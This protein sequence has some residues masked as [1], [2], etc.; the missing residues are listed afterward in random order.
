MIRPIEGNLF[1]TMMFLKQCFKKFLYKKCRSKRGCFGCLNKENQVNTAKQTPIGK[2]KTLGLETT[3]HRALTMS[4]TSYCIEKTDFL[5]S[6]G[7]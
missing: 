4:K 1:M 5:D 6:I 2:A 7:Y 3:F